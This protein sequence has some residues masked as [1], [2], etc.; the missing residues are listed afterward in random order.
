MQSI[1]AVLAMLLILSN[2]IYSQSTHALH[3]QLYGN[4]ESV[5]KNVETNQPFYSSL[6]KS[7]K[8]LNGVV[9]GYLPYWE[10]DNPT[11]RYDLLTHIALFDFEADSLGKISLPPSFPTSWNS[12]ISQARLNDVKLIMCVTNFDASQIN[13]LLSSTQAKTT[14]KN[15][16]VS[17]LKQYSLDGVNIDFEGLAT[18]D[19]GTPINTFMTELTAFVHTEVPGSEVSFA[20]PVINWS[21]WNLPGL[22][23]SCDYLFIMG[24]DFYGSWSDV[25][26]PSAPLIG[27]TYNI[28]YALS[29]NN[30]Y[31]QLV[32]S[33]PKK[34]I[35][36]LPFYG[37]KWQTKSLTSGDSVVKYLGSLLYRN[38]YPQSLQYGKL[39]SSKYLVPYFTYTSSGKYY[40]AWFDDSLSL[41]MKFN[42]AKEKN[43]RGVG[44]WALNYDKGYNHLWQIIENRFVVSTDQTEVPDPNSR[45]KN[46]VVAS[47]YD[48]EETVLKIQSF[49]DQSVILQLFSITGEMLYQQN[50]EISSGETILLSLNQKVLSSTVVIYAVTTPT[51]FVTGKCIVVK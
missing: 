47:Y 22:A 44:M 40:Q 42:L 17:I 15:S 18:T 45:N 46:L 25:A 19:R 32:S 23:N 2:T 5:I 38:A 9:F 29:S 7:K 4:S 16:I 48:E 24:Y 36:G 3:K 26:G 27:D 6:P 50:Y 35:L 30:H 28:T 37:N 39:W 49:N 12:V 34:L 31:G 11:L 10:I 21:S 51:G 43:L 20:A 41:G 33:M 13:F 1:Y 14:I 8:E